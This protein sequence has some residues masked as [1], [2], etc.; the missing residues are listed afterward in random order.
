MKV[1]IAGA[2]FF[3]LDEDGEILRVLPETKNI[4]FN[5]TYAPVPIGAVLKI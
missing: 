1:V 2:Y 5:L 3:V 4:L